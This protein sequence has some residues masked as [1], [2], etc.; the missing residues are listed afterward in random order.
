M[1]DPIQIFLLSEMNYSSEETLRIVL[2]EYT[3]NGT[4]KKFSIKTCKESHIKS[5]IIQQDY[6]DKYE[7]DYYD[8]N[9]LVIIPETISRFVAVETIKISAC[10]EELPLALSK[11]SHLKLLDLS[12]CYNLLSIPE[13]ILKM[14]DLKIK[15][16]DIISRAPEVVFIKVTPTGITQEAFSMIRSANKKR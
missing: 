3:S 11:L 6:Y 8:G 2:P 13:D 16:G 9:R 12:G 5:L 10:I 15:S 7:R 4:D 1:I 14:K